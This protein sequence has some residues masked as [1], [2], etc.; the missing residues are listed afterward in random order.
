MMICLG[1]GDLKASV[2]PPQEALEMLLFGGRQKPDSHPLANY[3]YAG[4]WSPPCSKGVV[5]GSCG[6]VSEQQTP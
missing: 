6:A 5:P 1:G 4:K 3:R 2:P